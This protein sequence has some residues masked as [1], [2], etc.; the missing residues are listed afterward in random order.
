MY[1][2]PVLAVVAESAI[3]PAYVSITCPELLRLSV[4]A[5]GYGASGTRDTGLTPTIHFTLSPE[6]QQ[7]TWAVPSLLPEL[8]SKHL[9]A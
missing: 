3:Q 9:P 8:S 7:I 1:H 2:R 6:Q 5:K 4:S